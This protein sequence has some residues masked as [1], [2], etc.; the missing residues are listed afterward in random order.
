MAFPGLQASHSRI[1]SSSHEECTISPL[2]SVG[3]ESSSTKSTGNYYEEPLEKQFICP[4]CRKNTSLN[5][6]NDGNESSY[7]FTSLVGLAKHIGKVHQNGGQDESTKVASSHFVS[8][9]SSN[10]SCNSNNGLLLASPFLGGRTNS[11][12]SGSQLMSQ[13]TTLDLSSRK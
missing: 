5:N 6:N 4:F 1:S 7:A 3:S 9:N 13:S 11:S 12:S 8:S 10:S 2:S